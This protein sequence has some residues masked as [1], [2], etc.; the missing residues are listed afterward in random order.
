MPPNTYLS[1]INETLFY[2][3]EAATS[4]ERCFILK[5]LRPWFWAATGIFW[6]GN[7]YLSI[8]LHTSIKAYN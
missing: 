5:R 6:S 4:I 3:K 1:V 2:S 7:S 8:Y